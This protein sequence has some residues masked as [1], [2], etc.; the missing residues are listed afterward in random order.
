MR[1]HIM[2]LPN[3]GFDLGN[4][5]CEWSGY[6]LDFDRCPSK[7]Q[8]IEFLAT[9]FDAF[10]SGTK[11]DKEE[12]ERGIEALY[13]ESVRWMMASHLQWYMWAKI[14][15]KISNLKFDYVEYGN[16]RLTQYYKIKACLS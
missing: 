4:H 15:S 2:Y 14:Q 5:F 3:R 9:Y 1:N 7:E 6:D 12:R 13:Q 8:S 10:H 16:K 11:I